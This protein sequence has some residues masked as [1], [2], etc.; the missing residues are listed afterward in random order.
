MQLLSKE[1]KHIELSDNIILLLSFCAGISFLGGLTGISVITSISFS[2]SIFSVLL[3]VAW[4]L[5]KK[6]TV[7]FLFLSLLVLI[8][9][10][11]INSGLT[12][13]FSYYKRAIITICTF[14]CIFYSPYTKITENTKKLIG[15]VFNVASLLTIFYFYFLGYD[16]KGFG[17]TTLVA[18]NFSN[19]NEAGL[20]I[21]ILFI[22]LF[23][24]VFTTRKKIVKVLFFIEAC[25]LFHILSATGSRNS[26]LSGLLFVIVRIILQFFKI[27]KFPKWV[28]GLFVLLPIIVFF[29]YM[30][31]FLPNIKLFESLFSFLD[32]DKSLTSR[33]KIWQSVINNLKNCFLLGDYSKFHEGQLHNSLMTLFV[34]FGFPFTLLSCIFIYRCCKQL[35]SHL[36]IEAAFT[37]CAILFTGCFEASVF[38]GIGGIYIALLIIPIYTT[39]LNHYNK[40]MQ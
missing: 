5:I 35:Q 28:L 14:I 26:L 3:I 24:N 34:M 29:V 8:G 18:F 1:N 7:D 40:T 23:S 32:S 20:W 38:V 22:A 39:N 6:G 9:L 27:K 13:N 10:S 11:I 17:S 16:K 31:V 19:P 2:I 37:M 36:S 25:F 12:L 4:D 21:F 33:D 15:F 30:F